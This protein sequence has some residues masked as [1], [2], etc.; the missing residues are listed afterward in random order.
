MRSGFQFPD[1]NYGSYGDFGV[2]DID[3]DGIA[4]LM[5]YALGLPPLA[6]GGSPLFGG[7][8]TS[9]PAGSFLTVAVPRD[10]ARHDVMLTA[11]ASG[12]LSGPWTALAVSIGGA[13][14]TG[15]G[16]VSGDSAAAGLKSV[17]IRDV[18]ST[19]SARRRFLRLR[20]SR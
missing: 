4:N 20:A 5:E 2:C 17:V 18:V 13:P 14:F 15:P 19:S 1:G 6:A 3:G 12:S 10:P 16:Y 8:F 9:S 7:Y 11:E